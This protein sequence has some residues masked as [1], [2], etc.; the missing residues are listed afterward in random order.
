MDWHRHH[1]P[2]A[3]RR[4][5]LRDPG[6][7]LFHLGDLDPG[8]WEH[9]DYLAL[10]EPNDPDALLLIY[11]G[12]SVPCVIA[13]GDE[14]ALGD[15]FSSA[16][17]RFPADGFIHGFD[18]DLRA[19]EGRAEVTRRGL[20]RRMSWRGFPADGRDE[21]IDRAT[22]L[23]ASDLDDL[24]ALYADSYPDAHFEP[25]QLEKGLLFGVREGGRLLSAAGLHVLA[26]SEGVAMLGNIATHRDRRGEGLAGAATAAL[27]AHL[28]RSIPHIGL[29]V[30]AGNA[31]A[32]QLYRRLGFIEEFLYEEAS[33]R[34]RSRSSR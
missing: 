8:E 25:V 3:L 7:Y 4:F 23:D 17:D 1:D 28:S 20:F 24:Q 14:G 33:Y 2:E 31:A 13:F 26:E 27:L 9:S 18:E 21:G 32:R 30:H 10:G 29:N 34:A 15:P 5:C 22:R 12:L 19:L 11:R 6:R 16:L